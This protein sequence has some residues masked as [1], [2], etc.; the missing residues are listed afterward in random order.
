MLFSALSSPI[1]PPSG[2]LIN[3][4]RR[5]HRLFPRVSA[6]GGVNG[7]GG[8]GEGGGEVVEYTPWLV[9]GL[10]NPGSKYHGTRH[11][12]GFEMIDKISKR[13]GIVLNTIQSKAL[14]G[15]GS[16]GEVPV[17][18]AKPQAYMSYS[19][20]SVGPLAAYYGVPLRHILLVYDEMSLVNGVLKLQ[21]RGGQGG[22]H[23]GNW[24]SSWKDGYESISSAE[25]QSNGT[26]TGRCDC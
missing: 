1:P 17:L 3:F 19:G 15:I 24:K 25:I 2:T 9:V 12:V 7:A 14:I 5:Q 18:L 8:V 20:E 23:N 21:P 22:H 4:R 16:I 13:E 11:N 6:C 10:G 26:K